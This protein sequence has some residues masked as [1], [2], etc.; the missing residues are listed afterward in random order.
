[1]SVEFICIVLTSKEFF[2]LY[3]NETFNTDS[4]FDDVVI[5]ITHPNRNRRYV[6]IILHITQGK[7]C[8]LMLQKLGWT[9]NYRLHRNSQVLLMDF[10]PKFGWTIFG[11]IRPF[12]QPKPL[13]IFRPPARWPSTLVY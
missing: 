9:S 4:L 5:N 7:R 11:D 12:S 2:H 3:D 6:A 1:M 10:D 8:G 13:S